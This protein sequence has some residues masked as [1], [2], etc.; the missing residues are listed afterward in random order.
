MIFVGSKAPRGSSILRRTLKNSQGQPSTGSSI[1]LIT[2][3][4]AGKQNA[5]KNPK[6]ASPSRGALDAREGPW[7]IADRR[8]WVVAVNVGLAV[9]ASV[10]SHAATF[11]DIVVLAFLKKIRRV[12]FGQLS[13]SSFI[14]EGVSVMRRPVVATP[15]ASTKE[16]NLIGHFVGLDVRC[17]GCYRGFGDVMIQA[18]TSECSLL[19]WPRLRRFKYRLYYN[20]YFVRCASFNHHAHFHR[21]VA[22]CRSEVGRPHISNS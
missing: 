22:R 6:R 17:R 10:W 21:I 13:Q 11:I 15:A 5:H 1:A 4:F 12:P 19:D 20:R 2:G 8:F 9:V 3:L 14:D 7:L 16:L 18:L